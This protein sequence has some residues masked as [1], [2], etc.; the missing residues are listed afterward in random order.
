MHR[1]VYP[2]PKCGALALQQAGIVILMLKEV[3][4]TTIL[5]ITEIDTKSS[6]PA[7]LLACPDASFFTY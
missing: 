4:G 7:S 2:R 5:H 6:A 1:L 3:I